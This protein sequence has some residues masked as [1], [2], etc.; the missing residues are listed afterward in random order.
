MVSTRTRKFALALVF[1]DEASTWIKTVTKFHL[2]IE[3]AQIL[4]VKC[5]LKALNGLFAVLS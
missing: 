5:G 2:N 3:L 1:S 4:L